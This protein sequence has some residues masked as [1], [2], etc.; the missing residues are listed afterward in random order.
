MML[1]WPLKMSTTIL[2]GKMEGI[3]FEIDVS[4]RRLSCNQE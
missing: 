3:A 2:S 4:L 1:V